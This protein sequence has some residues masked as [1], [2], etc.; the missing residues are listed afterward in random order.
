M[1]P[2]KINTPQFDLAIHILAQ[3]KGLLLLPK[4]SWPRFLDYQYIERRLKKL[5]EDDLDTLMTGE[6]MEVS[7]LVKAHS[8][9]PLDT[10]FNC[11]FNEEIKGFFYEESKKGRA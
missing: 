6:M 4:D 3:D 11:I 8:L 2:N 1:N 10:M 9:Q 7:E 5:S